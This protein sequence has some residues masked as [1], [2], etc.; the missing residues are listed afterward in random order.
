[1]RERPSSEYR[2]WNITLPFSVPS[3]H[4][5]AVLTDALVQRCA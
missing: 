2:D 4:V 5:E 3:G 1:M